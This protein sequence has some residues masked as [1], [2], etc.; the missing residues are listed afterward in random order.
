MF[1]KYMLALKGGESIEISPTIDETTSPFLIGRQYFPRDEN[2]SG[3][4]LSQRL[5]VVYYPPPPPPLKKWGEGGS[6]WNF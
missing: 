3:A 6:L 1:D 2:P 5:L 4:T